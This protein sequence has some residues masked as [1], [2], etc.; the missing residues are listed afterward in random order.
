MKLYSVFAFLFCCAF[1]FAAAQTNLVP[2]PSFE[3]YTL[4]PSG[5]DQMNRCIGWSSYRE[6]PDFYHTCSPTAGMAP[7]NA[8]FGFQFPHTG[9]GYAGISCYDSLTSNYREYMGIALSS[10][11]Q[12]GEKYYVSFFL[13]LA[14]TQWYR[15]GTNKV[16]L[17]F[18]TT[19]YS[20]S[21]PVP[22]S[23]FAHVYSASAVT[24][25]SNW[26]QVFSS[27]T[28]DSSYAY[29]SLGNF[30][31]DA[32]TD[33]AKLGSFNFT[34]Y[35]YIDD[36]CVSTDSIYSLNWTGI[37]NTEVDKEI[38]VYPNP[39]SNE[40]NVEFMHVIPLKVSLINSLGV[41]AVEQLISPHERSLKIMVEHLPQGFYTLRLEYSGFI[42]SRK[43]IVTHP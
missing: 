36:V 2:N 4:C 21:S 37:Y 30:F 12:A 9:N 28:A 40:V 42:T 8:A 16:G 39:S 13:N 32:N 17:R 24:D 26:V 33:T 1:H 5:L 27:F 10:P 35:Y 15:L 34:N 41:T 38:R 22:I 6:S 25:T 7:P 19:S 31:D 3:Q 23:N 29:L 20:L 11:L 43:I 18:S 14:G